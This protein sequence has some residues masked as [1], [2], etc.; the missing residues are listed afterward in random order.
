MSVVVVLWVELSVH[1][2][3]FLFILNSLVDHLLITH[4]LVTHLLAHF[5][6]QVGDLLLKAFLYLLL[7][8]SSDQ[9]SHVN[10]NGLKIVELLSLVI[11]S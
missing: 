6:L 9:R 11:N 4:L 3:S 2:L 8:N 5:F 1:L 7:N 10:W